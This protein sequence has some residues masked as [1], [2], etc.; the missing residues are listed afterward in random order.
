VTVKKAGFSIAVPNSWSAVDFGLDPKLLQ[1]VLKKFQKANPSVH[2]TENEATYVENHIALLASDP[3][4]EA[5]GL[6]VVFVAGKFPEPSTSDVRQILAGV[7]NVAIRA[8]ALGR[9]PAIEA[10]FAV[11]EN[12]P[13]GT[14]VNAFHTQY[15]ISGK[16][17][18]LQFDFNTQDDNQH[19]QVRNTMIH[20][21]RL[22]R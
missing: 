11:E 1:A 13:D 6:Q 19:A 17:G 7:P 5:K 14:R 10:I 8:I 2:V 21:L 18:F 9:L 12:L 15:Y 4:N 16:K 3:S 20:S 22:L